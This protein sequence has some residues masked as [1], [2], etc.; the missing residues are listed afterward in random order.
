MLF[1]ELSQSFY[2]SLVKIVCSITRFYTW[3]IA[4]IS[5]L[6]PGSNDLIL[7]L[8]FRSCPV[9]SI[10][11]C[12]A[13]WWIFSVTARIWKDSG[14]RTCR[15]FSVYVQNPLQPVY[16]FWLISRVLK[17]KLHT[18][19]SEI[20]KEIRLN[21]AVQYLSKTTMPIEQVAQTVGY[22][23]ITHFYTLFRSKYQMSPK[24]YRL[25]YQQ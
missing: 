11:F 12:G 10:I 5:T 25:E 23:N 16:A 15:N 18:G 2:T 20:I 19:F 9:Y 22:Q 8:A 1:P 13:S 14:S 21:H 3:R 24:E 6:A 7:T 4:V 17:N